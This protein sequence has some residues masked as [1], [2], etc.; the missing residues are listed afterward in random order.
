MDF[1]TA[2]DFIALMSAF[3]SA[4]LKMK[5]VSFDEYL[6]DITFSKNNFHTFRLAMYC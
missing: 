1:A 2:M 6:R 4:A 5:K 3:A